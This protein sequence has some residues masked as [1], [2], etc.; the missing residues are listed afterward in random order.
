[1]PFLLD[2]F[3]DVM[4]DT[5]EIFRCFLG[6]LKT[7]KFRSEISLNFKGALQSHKIREHR[8][9][10]FECTNCPKKFRT[11]GLLMYHVC[12]ASDNETQF[13]CP[14]CDYVHDRRQFMRH[15]KASSFTQSNIFVTF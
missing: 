9:K 2:H 1:M 7:P 13:K 6:E 3:L 4:A 12:D 10:K 8:T 14:K 5:R 11:K 15:H